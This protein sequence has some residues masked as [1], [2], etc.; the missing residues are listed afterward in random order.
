MNS[1]KWFKRK[2]NFDIL[3]G[4]FPS[5]LERLEGT[6]LRLSNKMVHIPSEK[7]EVQ[8]NNS[9]SIKEN[10]GHLIDLE[11]LWYG[12]VVDITENKETLREADLENKKTHDANHNTTR[13]PTLLNAFAQQR[14]QF[15]ELLKANRDHAESLSALHPRIL[16]PMRIIDLAFFV[17]EHDDH[18]LARITEIDENIV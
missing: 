16:Q 5:I 18:H 1:I 3:Q 6:P 4:T 9:W 13:L 2:F 14:K 17:A 15:V 12:R 11:P 10:I 8:W 7:L